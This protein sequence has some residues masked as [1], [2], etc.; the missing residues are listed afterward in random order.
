MGSALSE[1]EIRSPWFQNAEVSDTTEDAMKNY[2]WLTKNTHHFFNH[3]RYTSEH[4]LCTF[5]KNNYALFVYF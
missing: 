1:A 2:S 3:H 5:L 4:Y